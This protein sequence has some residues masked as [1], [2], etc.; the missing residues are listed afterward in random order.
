MAYA[1]EG[2]MATPIGV[3]RNKRP[4][5]SKDD[6]RLGYILGYPLSMETTILVAQV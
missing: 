2:T 5:N 3:Y 4:Q 6:A 1:K